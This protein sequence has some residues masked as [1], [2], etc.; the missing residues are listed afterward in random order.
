M[1]GTSKEMREERERERERERSRCGRKPLERHWERW[2][3]RMGDGAE[4]KLLNVATKWNG[5]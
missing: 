3:R 1:P 2:G 4:G 5:N